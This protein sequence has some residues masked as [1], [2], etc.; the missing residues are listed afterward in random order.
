VSAPDRMRPPEPGALRPFDVPPV[1]KRAGEGGL[2]LRVVRL[3]R[4]P[5]VTAAFVL[6]AG[7]AGVARERAGLAVLTANALEGGT[8]RRSGTAL[9]EALESVGADVSVDATW[10]ATLASVSC[11]ADRLPEALDLLVEMI[12]AP[13]FPDGEVERAREQALARIRHRAKDPSALASDR[14]AELFYAPGEPYG[15]PAAGTLD[16]VEPLD[17][18]ALKA[19]ARDHYRPAGAGLVVAGDVDVAEIEDLT[20]RLL[21]GWEGAPPPSPVV[22]G[23]PRTRTR[24]V[25]VIHRPGSVQSEFRIGH[26]GVGRDTPDYPSLVVANAILGGTFTSRLNL[27][28]REERGFTYGVRSGFAFRRGPGPFSVRTAVDTEVTADAVSEAVGEVTGLVAD[29][30]TRAEVEAARDYIAG[31]FPLRLETTGQVAGRVAELVIHGLPD[32]AWTRYR[33]EIRAVTPASAG[34]ALRRHVRPDEFTVVV[35]GDADRVRAPLEALELG[36]VLVHE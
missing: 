1:E 4:L 16:S 2:D 31:V 22:G 12:L 14:A 7:E 29:G 9:A 6:P 10:D 15:R 17:T 19:F 11:L 21:S 18:A 36:P 33:D 35:V 26:P 8:K 27:N 24:T 23:T 28:L 13:S 3:P 34:E 32:D 20:H 25:H 30:P 5:V